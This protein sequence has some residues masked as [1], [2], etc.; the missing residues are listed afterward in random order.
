M[1]S[2]QNN[3]NIVTLFIGTFIFAHPSE[4][5]YVSLSFGP[6]VTDTDSTT[7]HID[8]KSNVEIAGFQFSV[9]GVNITNV[10]GGAATDAGFTITTSPSLVLGF[11]FTG[12]TIPAASTEKHLIKLKFTTPSD[13]TSDP[14]WIDNAGYN[15][16]ATMTAAVIGAGV[17]LSDTNDILAAF[18]DEGNVRSLDFPQ[19]VP[20]PF[21]NEGDVVHQ[22]TLRSNAQGDHLTFKFYDSD[23]ETIYE[24]SDSIEFI[25]DM[26]LGNVMSPIILNA[27]GDGITD[28]Q[29]CT[30]NA[31]IA[32]DGEYTLSSSGTVDE[33]TLTI[34][35]TFTTEAVG[36]SITI[37][38]V[39]LAVA[40]GSVS[41]TT[42]TNL[43]RLLSLAVID[44]IKAQMSL[45]KGDAQMKEYYMRE[46]YKKLADNESNKRKISISFASPVS[47]VR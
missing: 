8:Y 39:P 15:F 22:L 34:T 5:D 30:N 33:D 40:D 20:F 25:S 38:Q 1:K 31:P 41:E 3:Y 16:I 2:M 9:N 4:S 17:Q 36:E 7:I 42:H 21:P 28:Y 14:N 23:S 10:S 32:N 29:N 24:I 11:S 13:W 27:T 44:Y 45:E 46:F 18:D 19:E 37:Y 12:A 26:I 35:G 6:I 43:N 47:S